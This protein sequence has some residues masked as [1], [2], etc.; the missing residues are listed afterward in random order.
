MGHSSL[1]VMQCLA[2]CDCDSQSFKRI[3]IH[4]GF[5]LLN[6]FN[7]FRHPYLHKNK[8]P[9][10]RRILELQCTEEHYKLKSMSLMF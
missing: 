3:L 8:S 2:L 5:L 6:Q 9:L 1:C 10:L 7:M 4:H